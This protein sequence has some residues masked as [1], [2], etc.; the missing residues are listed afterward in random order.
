MESSHTQRLPD[1]HSEEINTR[2]I[3]PRATNKRHSILKMELQEDAGP[4]SDKK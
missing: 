4:N 1:N 2:L 3:S